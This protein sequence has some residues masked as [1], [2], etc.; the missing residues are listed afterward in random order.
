MRARDGMIGRGR[1]A[2]VYSDHDERGRPIARKVF[3]GEGVAKAVLYLLTGG[4]AEAK[5]A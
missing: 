3:V 2:A 5:H 1:S 4:E